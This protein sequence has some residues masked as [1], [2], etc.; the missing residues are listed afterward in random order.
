[1]DLYGASKG[2]TDDQRL[3]LVGKSL[4]RIFLES[5]EVTVGG[6][7]VT[8]EQRDEYNTVTRKLVPLFYHRLSHPESA[9]R[10]EKLPKSV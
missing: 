7:K 5:K 1:V 4:K 8:R 2:M 10:E 3:M 6:F 9:P